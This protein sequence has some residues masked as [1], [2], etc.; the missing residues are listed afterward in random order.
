MLIYGQQDQHTTNVIDSLLQLDVRVKGKQQTLSALDS[1][2]NLSTAIEDTARIAKSHLKIADTY[3][4]IGELDDVKPHLI[5]SLDLFRKLGDSSQVV[6]TMRKIGNYYKG[7]GSFEEA[8]NTYL[9]ALKIA[10]YENLNESVITLK[11][12]LGTVYDDLDLPDQAI[13]YYREVYQMEPKGDLLQTLLS[14]MAIAFRRINQTD[15]AMHYLNIG[16]SKCHGKDSVYCKIIFFNGLS[17]LFR[18][19]KQLD[20]SLF[21]LDKVVSYYEA[22]ELKHDLI[23]VYNSMALTYMELGECQPAL[24]YYYKSLDL[25]DET[26]FKNIHYIY[27]NLAEA[28]NCLKRHGLAYYYLNKHIKL[29]DSIDKIKVNQR[30]DDLYVEYETKQKEQQILLLEKENDLQESEIRRQSTI[31]Q[32]SIIIASVIVLAA[33]I[34]IWI[35]QQK[36]KTSKLLASRTDELNRKQTEALVQEYELK[37]IKAAVDGKEKERVRISKALHDGVAGSLAGIKLSLEKLPS[38]KEFS[39][40]EKIKSQV[41]NV[42]NDIRSISEDLSPIHIEEDR[43]WNFLIN[44]IL[45]VTDMHDFQVEVNNSLSNKELILD[46]KIQLE[47]YRV[48]QELLNNVIKHAEASHV[49]ISFNQ[50]QDTLNIMI[51][52][53]GKGFRAKRI[54]KGMGLRNINE[55]MKS[56]QGNVHVDSV[57]GRGTITT[58]EIP[59]R[60]EAMA[61]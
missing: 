47:L 1:A 24:F 33:S 55:R 40:V 57:V 36:V 29:R 13:S 39:H 37:Q 46:T 26:D 20:S 2:L 60:E 58:I 61:Q 45:E 43:F 3:I 17:H 19:I 42:Y 41:S 18:E 59:I 53:N 11:L 52:D 50:N 25:A 35:Y 34:L 51:E 9:N 48:V 10:Q 16:L 44:Y 4:E 5:A 56:I 54:S 38:L 22:K 23:I 8:V 12:N 14:N 49:E 32:A 31:N 27:F 6:T 7:K 15:S 21:Y 30:F 28:A